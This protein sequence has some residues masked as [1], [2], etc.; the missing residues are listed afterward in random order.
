MR[1]SL[2]DSGISMEAEAKQAYIA[3]KMEKL[4]HSPPVAVAAAESF[5]PP[6]GWAYERYAL[7]ECKV[8]RLENPA[9]CSCRSWRTVWIPSRKFVISC[10]GI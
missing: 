4:F 7:G 2:P 10:I 5:S 3:E 9:A 1:G 6:E 8:E